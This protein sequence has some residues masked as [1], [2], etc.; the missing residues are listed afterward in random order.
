MSLSDTSCGECS[1][2][3]EALTFDLGPLHKPSGV[4]CPHCRAPHGCA[5]YDTRWEVCRTYHC[6]WRHL[7]LPEE[8]RPDRSEILIFLR[9]GPAPDGLQNGVEFELVGSHDRLT[10]MPLVKFIAALIEDKT[11]VYLSIQGGLASPWVYL[12][13]IPALIDGISRRDLNATT[14]ALRDALQVCIDYP[15]TDTP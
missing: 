7:G 12:N 11:P 10:W 2:C 3:C 15:K 9:E 6:G 13:N 5:V 14:A 8:W 1:V 4:K